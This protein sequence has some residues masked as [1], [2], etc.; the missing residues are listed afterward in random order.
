MRTNGGSRS[1]FTGYL[2]EKQPEPSEYQRLD[3][4]D[5]SLMLK[6]SRDDERLAEEER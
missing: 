6:L 1:R 4:E 5:V 3:Y 2:E